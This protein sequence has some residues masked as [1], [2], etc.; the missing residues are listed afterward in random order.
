MT[1]TEPNAG[2]N[3]IWY[4]VQFKPEPQAGETVL[5]EFADPEPQKAVATCSAADGLPAASAER[6]AVLDVLAVPCE[7]KQ[8]SRGRRDLRSL[9]EPPGQDETPPVAVKVEDVLVL[10][11]PGRAI[12]QAPPARVETILPALAEFAFYEGQ[13][14]K[15]EDEIAAA[16]PEA[17]AD[18]P[19]THDASRVDALHREVLA[20]RCTEVF[21]RRIRCTRIEPHLDSPSAAMAPVARQLGEML[22]EK[23]EIEDRIEYLDGKLEVFEYTYEMISQRLSDYTHYRHGMLLEVLIVVFLAAEVLLMMYECYLSYMVE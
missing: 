20:R 1:N 22:R 13:L 5:C 3:A 18:S 2:L 17:E 7:G 11:R 15:L 8:D 23:V 16:W 6:Y 21:R 19:V 4:R 9:L 14:R 10:W 12:V